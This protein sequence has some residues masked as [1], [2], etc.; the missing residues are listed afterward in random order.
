MLSRMNVR[1]VI[2]FL[3]RQF[4]VCKRIFW[5][6]LLLL[7]LPKMPIPFLSPFPPSSLS[8]FPSQIPR[9]Q[10]VGECLSGLTAASEGGSGY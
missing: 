10:A 8:L 2:A 7:L 5:V 4:E 6:P 3:S 9:F 1:K